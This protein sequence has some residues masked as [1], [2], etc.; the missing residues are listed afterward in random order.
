VFAKQARTVHTSNHEF[1]FCASK[2]DWGIQKQ[3]HER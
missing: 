1:T 3:H 2:Y